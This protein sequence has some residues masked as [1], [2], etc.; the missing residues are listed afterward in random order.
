MSLLEKEKEILEKC[1]SEWES[2]EYP[3]A[4]KE[5]ENKLEEI[6][7]AINILMSI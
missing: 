7:K 1:L 5:R 6:N 4:R 3:Q 2:I